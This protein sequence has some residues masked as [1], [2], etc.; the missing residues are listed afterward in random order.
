[1]RLILAIAILLSVSV[2]AWAEEAQLTGV[3]VGNNEQ[4]ARVVVETSSIVP[5][6][7]LLLSKPYRLVVDMPRMR[8]SV[9]GKEKNGKLESPL[10]V[11]YRFGMPKEGVSRFVVDMSASAIPIKIF[12]LPPNKSGSGY[13]LVI[14]L[15]E[16]GETAFQLAARAFRYQQGNE[17]PVEEEKTAAVSKKDLAL[18]KSRLGSSKAVRK[19]DKWVV[20]IDPG[21]G[22]VDPGAISLSGIKEKDITLR[23]ALELAKQM[24]ATGKIKA[25]L[26]RRGD[27]FHRLRKRIALAR[28]VEADVFISLHADAAPNKKAM[29]VSVFTLSEQ[30]SDKEAA[31]L[32]AR[33]NKADLITGADLGST[34][35]EVTSALL[36]MFQRASMNQSAVLAAHISQE[37]DTLPTA[38]RGHRFAGFAV[39]KS[40]DTPSV[41]IEMGFLTN[42]AD[43]KQLKSSAYRRDLMERITRATL[44]YLEE[45]AIESP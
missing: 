4:V 23:A 16:R 31:L 12:R 28:E 35:P 1:M 32:A 43:E 5:V 7:F 41:L 15:I 21:H 22:G 14:D 6:Q 29:G 2:S 17:F 18:A 38:Q 24:E 20:F 19:D 40:P 45:S 11:G 13:R 30:A 44:L 26:S 34:D 37:L 36:K 42:Q 9:K 8:W 3:R 10:F 27:Q 33:E 39:L 25:I